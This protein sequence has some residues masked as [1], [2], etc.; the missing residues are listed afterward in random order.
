MNKNEETVI[1]KK[2]GLGTNNSNN[3]GTKL[4]RILLAIIILLLLVGLVM[5]GVLYKKQSDR[6]TRL[7]SAQDSLEQE[8][9]KEK[10]DNEKN[11]DDLIAKIATLRS[12]LVDDVPADLQAQ[13]QDLLS[14]INQ[15]SNSADSQTAASAKQLLQSLTNQAGEGILLSGSN[16]TT[17][18]NSGVLS[19]NGSGGAISIQGTPNQTNVIQ[20]GGTTKVGTVQDIAS[21]SSPTFKNQTLTGNSTVQG[22]INTDTLTIQNSGTQNGYNLCDS[23]NNCG[24]SGAGSSFVQGGNSFGNPAY[25]G[26][27]DSNSLNLETNGVTRLNLDTAGNSNFSGDINTPGSVSASSF[28]GDGTNVSNVNATQLGGQNASYYQNANNINAGT[29]SDGRLSANVT[30]QGNA[31]NGVNQLV[32]LTSGGILP[33][34]DGQQLTNVLAANSTQLGGQGAAY[35]LNASNLNSGTLSDTL[36]S[37]NVTLQ[38]NTFNGPNQ[39]VKLGAGGLLPVLNGSNLTG[40]DAATLNGQLAV[41]YLN[42]GN[43]GTG[44]LADARLS[45]NVALK[46]A[47]NAFTG[48]NNFAGL[49]ATGILQNGYSVCDTS[50]NCNYATSGQFANA[51]LQGGNSFGSALS[52]GTNDNQS[53]ALRTN[54]TD[55]LTML[56]NGNIGIGTAVPSSQLDVRVP[57]LGLPVFSVNDG[58]YTINLGYGS[59]AIGSNRLSIYRNSST[60]YYDN[61]SG[62]HVFTTNATSTPLQIVR[63][64]SSGLN[65]VQANAQLNVGISQKG[66]L[67]IGTQTNY[68]NNFINTASLCMDTACLKGD[69]GNTL[70]AS[71][72]NGAFAGSRLKSD[73]LLANKLQ[74]ASNGVTALTISEVL[75]NT[76]AHIGLNSA[77]SNSVAALF[78]TSGVGN[79]NLAVQAMSGQTADLIQA[80]DSSGA[81]LF[82]VLTDGRLRTIGGT[83]TNVLLG[84][85]NNSGLFI[86]G[87]GQVP[88]FSSAGLQSACFRGSGV[89]VYPPGSLASPALYFAGDNSTGIYRPAV[90]SLAF[91][92]GSIEALRISSTALLVSVSPQ[93]SGNYITFSNNVRGYNVGVTASATSQAVTFT[94]AHPDA[95]YA[96]FCTPDWNT[97]CYVSNK[98]TT[99]FTLNYG[100]AA[101]AGQLVDWFVAR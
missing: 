59:S 88:C 10:L 4:G 78:G 61:S 94:T 19:V 66:Y 55:R 49:T 21:T 84:V 28:T 44:T 76:K 50:N 43:I 57:T 80:Q 9:S 18:S 99:G 29:L 100:T 65:L 20:S 56:P 14:Q 2:S 90:G 1:K 72:S 83:S 68:A 54:G 60:T 93:F 87:S 37:G 24:Y 85:S 34:L 46:N 22:N 33:I 25:L 23:S 7:H 35:Y 11:L 71:L 70:I 31:F 62:S 26:T 36:L 51:I 40:V 92:A 53:F 38:G 96:V 16:N 39:L 98:T 27:N 41:Y 48:T 64:D 86:T 12:Q 5:A 8:L 75:S 67:A 47:T 74:S 89:E 82:R 6:I 101:P 95:N 97:T 69:G 79:V 15:L 81:S 30:L 45:S 77:T 58:F 17:I 52:I 42:A 91:S 32:R 13:Y 3:G 63:F 73:N